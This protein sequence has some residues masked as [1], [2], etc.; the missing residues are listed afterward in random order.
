MA[1]TK[2]KPRGKNDQGSDF[3]E[4]PEVISN[5]LSKTEAFLSQNKKMVFGIGGLIAVIIAAIFIYRYTME[6]KNATA[7]D[8][9]FQAVFYFENGNLGNALNGDGNSLGFLDIINDYSG[10]EAANLASFYAGAIYLQQREF[11]SALDMLK[12]FSSDDY[13][14]AARKHI[15][16]GDAYMELGNFTNAASAYQK[17]A[18]THPN[19]F[20]SPQYLMKAALAFESAGDNTKAIATYDE[21]INKYPESVELTNARKFKARLQA[22]AAN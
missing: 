4:N 3:L 6:T 8:E 17:G 9:M 12:D 16:I 19:K 7:Q 21:L 2:R 5:Q 11:Q 15:L 10:T 14:I 20:F 18:S 22:L 13:L 1:T